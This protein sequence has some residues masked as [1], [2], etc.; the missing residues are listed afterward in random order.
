MGAAECTGSPEPGAK[1]L[2]AWLLETYPLAWSLGIYNC[3]GVR[4]STTTSLHGEGR[5][6]D[7]GLPMVNGRAIPTGHRIVDRIGEH[8][9]R[10]GVQCAIY[11]RSI[12][13]ARSPQGRYY[14]GVHPHYDHIHIELTRASGKNLNLATLR[15]V[16]G[17]PEQEEDDV[18]AIKFGQGQDTPNGDDYV[19]RAQ[20]VM[21]AAASPSGLAVGLKIDGVYGPRTAEAV[22]TYAFKGQM[23][24]EGETGLHI[25]V[26]DYIRNWLR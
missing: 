21:N 18:Y 26:L 11:D 24:L 13:S 15:S 22:N 20:R 16:L 8:G 23:P 4:G 6:V 19:K 10:L 9:R 3:R 12:W 14:G 25:L 5:A 1:A 2:L 7:L 17:S